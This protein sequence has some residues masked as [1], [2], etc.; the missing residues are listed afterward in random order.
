MTEQDEYVGIDVSKK[1]LD[2]TTLHR[3]EHRTVHHDEEGISSICEQMLVLRPKLIVMEA[4]GGY[5]RELAI[6]LVLAGLPVAVVNPRQV[7]DF[8]KAMGMLAKT[9]KVDSGV[10]GLFGERI[11]PEPR[12]VPEKEVRELNALITRR[13]Q[14]KEMLTAEKNRMGVAPRTMRPSILE[15]VRWMESQVKELEAELNQVIQASPIWRAKEDLLTSVPGIGEVTA[16]SLIAMLP[17]LGHVTAK[18]AAALVGIAPFA[19]D[20]GPKKGKRS[21]WGGRASLRAA[22]YM[23]TLSAIRWN[24]VLRAHFKQLKARGKL[25]KVAM[26]A[27]MRRLLTILDAMVRKNQH[28]TDVTLVHAP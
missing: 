10:L 27:C 21:I 5:E 14:L 1:T 8:A 18:R 7:R 17:E 9:D 6:A 22:L 15:H 16:Q 2:V 28:W 23:A 24:P 12:G 25:F 11:R 19:R 3:G 20:S 13:A 26:V 4:T